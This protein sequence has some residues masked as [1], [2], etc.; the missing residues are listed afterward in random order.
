MIIPSDLSM[1]CK[2]LHFL[3]LVIIP[4]SISSSELR[5]QQF[6]VLLTSVFWDPVPC[7]SCQRLPLLII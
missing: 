1:I 4:H 6:D 5:E 7:F 2:G 3:S